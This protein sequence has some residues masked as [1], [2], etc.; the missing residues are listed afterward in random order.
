MTGFAGQSEGSV[1]NMA[2]KINALQPRKKE[3]PSNKLACSDRKVTVKKL[4]CKFG[5]REGEMFKNHSKM[6]IGL[7]LDQNQTAITDQRYRPTSCA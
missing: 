5:C 1:Y 6:N 4:A 7:K 2:C 3:E